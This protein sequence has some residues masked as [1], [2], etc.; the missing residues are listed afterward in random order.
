[1]AWV[2]RGEVIAA[3]PASALQTG[4]TVVVHSGEMIPVDGEILTGHGTIDQKTITGESLPVLR[5]EGEAV[6]AATGLREGYITIRATRGGEARPRR[7]KL[8][9]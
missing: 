3:I 6:Y 9:N 7:R 5:G 1:M 4:D 8:S 2:L